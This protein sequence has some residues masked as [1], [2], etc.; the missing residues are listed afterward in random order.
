MH[1][2][3]GLRGFRGDPSEHLEVARGTL[4][5]AVQF[6]DYAY[7]EAVDA[8]ERSGCQRAYDYYRQAVFYLSR[9]LAHHAEA[10][11]TFTKLSPAA[12][13]R[14]TAQDRDDA[15]WGIAAAKRAKGALNL[16]RARFLITEL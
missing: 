2:Y 15:E 13:R 7:R 14:F 6:Y 16:C 11:P 1:K 9:G 4:P 12:R 10:D 3:T 8:T 5:Q